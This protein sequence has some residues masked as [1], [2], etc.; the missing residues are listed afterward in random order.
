MK[1][2]LGK[3]FALSF[4][5][6]VSISILITSI[7]SNYM[8]DKKFDKYLLEEHE[9][10]IDKVKSLVEELYNPK[11]PFKKI[12]DSQIQRYAV[13]EDLYIQINDTYGNVVF[14]SGQSHLV[15]KKMMGSMMK[16]MM[17]RQSNSTLTSYKEESFPIMKNGENIGTIIIGYFGTSNLNERDIGFKNTLNQSFLISVII[18]FIF[19]F[20]ISLIM[21]KELTRPL[22]KIT[23]IANEMRNGNLKIR[24]EVNSNA[25]EID[26]LS[27]SINYLAQTLQDQEKLRKRLTSDMAHEIRTPLTTLQTHVEALMDGI[28]EPTPE[29]LQSCHEEILRLKKLVNHLQDLAR[30]EQGNLNLNKT[31]FSLSNTL[32][33]VIDTFKPQYAKKNLKIIMNIL[34]KVEVFM[35]EDKIKQILF[36]ILSNSYKYSNDDGVIEIGLKKDEK[37]IIIWIKDEGIGISNEHLPYI[38]ERFYR[39]EASRSRETGGAG[40]GLTITKTLV[41]AHGGKIE[42]ESEIGKGTT[43]IIK[44]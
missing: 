12:H 18:T 27:K 4:L 13:L 39:G 28:W 10:K 33:K 24:S 17:N 41:E 2:S 6:T 16:H 37:E 25:R 30:L 26:E 19:G 9:K 20:I 34:P 29:R 3:R 21:S 15:H 23:R 36:N 42:V 40:I 44:F 7:I 8:I 35:D 14:S 11:N 1:T 5:L 22:G 38:F 32:E 43:F 31:H